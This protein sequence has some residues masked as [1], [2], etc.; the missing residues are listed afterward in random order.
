MR[1]SARQLYDAAK[2]GEIDGALAYAPRTTIAVA[3]SQ[4]KLAVATGV[5]KLP[6]TVEAFAIRKGEQSL[7]NY[8]NAWVAYWSADGWIAERRKYWFESLDWTAR[9]APPTDSPAAAK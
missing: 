8:L 9:F 6:Q 1:R 2:A 5:G 7:L 3:E 4:G